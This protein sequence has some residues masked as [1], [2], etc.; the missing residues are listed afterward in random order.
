MTKK[1]IQMNDI[2]SPGKT[3]AKL[4]RTLSPEKEKQIKNIFKTPKKPLEKI[5]KLRRVAGLPYLSSRFFILFFILSFLVF[6]AVL[7]ISLPSTTLKLTPKSELQKFNFKITV[8]KYIQKIDLE[9]NLIPGQLIVISDEQ[10]KRYTSTGREYIE[11]KANGKLF[12]YN[13]YSSRTQPLIANTR[14][15][16]EDGKIFRI[17][18]KIIVPGMSGSKPGKIEVAVIADQVGAEYN[19]GP[20]KFQIPGFKEGGSPRYGAIYALSENPM[21]NG[22]KQEI[23]IVSQEDLL[24]AQDDFEQEVKHKA[25]LKLK[26]EIEKINGL[27]FLEQGVIEK[28][29]KILASTEP[30]DQA[31]AFNLTSYTELQTLA[32]MESALNSLIEA[33]ILENILENQTIAGPQDQIIFTEIAPKLEYGQLGFEINLEKIIEWK[34]DQQAIEHVIKNKNLNQIEEFLSDSPNIDKFEV[35]TWPSF[36]KFLP[37]S[38]KKIKIVVERDW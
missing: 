5:P 11:Q 16:S 10:V 17:Q 4:P 7:F 33:N 38:L 31:E 21:Q 6:T 2:F 1:F 34:I 23:L 30:G 35:K 22:L 25:D 12:V 24:S 18:E 15:E 36:L 29:F 14:F 26:N 13:A 32:F 3:Q 37:N 28:D 27:T 19:I 8:D 9:Q 20:S